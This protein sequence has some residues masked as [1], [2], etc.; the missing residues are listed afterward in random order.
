MWDITPEEMAA[1]HRGYV[2]GI[3]YGRK[4]AVEEIEEILKRY[5]PR[6]FLPLN[7]IRKIL[8]EVI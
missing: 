4:A 3:L 7:E 6:D 5:S 2:D 8:S 1:E